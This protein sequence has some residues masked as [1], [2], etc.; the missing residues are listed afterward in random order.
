MNAVQIN[1]SFCASEQNCSENEITKSSA[2]QEDC[3]FGE[4]HIAHRIAKALAYCVII[5]VSTL[6][7]SAIIT[8]IWRDRNMRKLPFNVFVVNLATADLVISLVYMSRTIVTC[9]QGHEWLVDGILGLVLCKTVPSLHAISILVSVLTLLAM[10]ADRFLVIVFPLRKKLSLSSSKQIASFIWLLSLAVRIPYIY[11]LRTEVR[12]STGELRCVVDVKKAFGNSQAREI[13]YTSL[14]VVFYGLPFVAITSL[15]SVIIKTLRQE[16][17]Q[18]NGSRLSQ[19]TLHRA[20]RKLFCMLLAITA[21]FVICWLTYFMAQVV[22]D[23]IPC[24]LRFWRLF[25]AH[26]NCSLNPLLYAVFNDK[27]RQGYKRLLHSTP[28]ACC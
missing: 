22:H 8:V 13:Y 26:V 6:G 15:Y 24:S 14:S 27:F 17:P 25:L 7:N 28:C 3:N 4:D 23:P 5:T 16:K 11:S 12:E 20:S 21:A 10:A 18:G 19:E 2:L 1:S 9:L